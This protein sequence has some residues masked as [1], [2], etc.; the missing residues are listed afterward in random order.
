MADLAADLVIGGDFA[1]ELVSGGALT[2]VALDAPFD[3]AV[4]TFTMSSLLDGSSVSVGGPS[5]VRLVLGGVRQEPDVD[6]SVDGT[7][8]N[9]FEAPLTSD[10]F[11]ALA[12]V[13][14]ITTPAVEEYRLYE[15]GAEHMFVR[16]DPSSDPTQPTE[17][18]LGLHLLEVNTP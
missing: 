17:E 14:Q 16:A 12:T 10:T 8:L 11:F 13:G 4:T 9:F 6:Y 15:D 7:A 1:W 3:G 5:Q 18:A 2:R